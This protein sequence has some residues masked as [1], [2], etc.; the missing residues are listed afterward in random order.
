MPQPLIPT[1]RSPNDDLLPIMIHHFG[2]TSSVV[3]LLLKKDKDISVGFVVDVDNAERLEVLVAA[4][5]VFGVD[6]YDE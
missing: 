1:P 3:V 2:R 4:A 5:V 6:Y